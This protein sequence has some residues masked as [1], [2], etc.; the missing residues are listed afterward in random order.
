VSLAFFILAMLGIGMA[1]S[2]S[3]LEQSPVIRVTQ[4]LAVVWLIYKTTTQFAQQPVVK[5]FAK[6][7]ILPIAVLY[8]FSWLDGIT[9]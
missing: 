4:G 8:V 3:L 1:V 7:M 2:D 6:C 5:L 9:A